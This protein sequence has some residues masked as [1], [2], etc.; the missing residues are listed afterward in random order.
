MSSADSPAPEPGAAHSTPSRSVVETVVVPIF[1]PGAA[2]PSRRGSDG[3]HPD[4]GSDV[5]V[6]ILGVP[7]ASPGSSLSRPSASRPATW[8]EAVANSMR[9]WTTS[10]AAISGLSSLPALRRAAANLRVNRMRLRCLDSLCASCE[11]FP[12]T[13]ASTTLNLR[14]AS[15]VRAD[16][17]VG[18]R[19]VPFGDKVKSTPTQ[20]QRMLCIAHPSGTVDNTTERSVS[21]RFTL[22]T[23]CGE[24]GYRNRTPFSIFTPVPQHFRPIRLRRR[25]SVA[26]RHLATAAEGC[27]LMLAQHAK[28]CRG[29]RNS[30]GLGSHQPCWNPVRETEILCCLRAIRE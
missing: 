15:A 22:K 26:S 4:P 14:W 12:S 19:L 9:P 21:Y 11:L 1:R 29:S 24:N 13:D 28:H 30:D 18:S 23:S 5:P 17:V 20:Q 7:T 6:L 27:W 3:L 2:H 10:P 8:E 25:P 16:Y